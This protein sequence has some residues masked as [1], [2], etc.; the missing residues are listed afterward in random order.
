[1]QGLWLTQVPTSNRVVAPNTTLH[2]LCIDRP[3][4]ALN[5]HY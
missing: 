3:R 1:L 4:E 2:R 5:G